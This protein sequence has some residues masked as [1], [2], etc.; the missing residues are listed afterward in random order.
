MNKNISQLEE[1]IKYTFKD[2]SLL[3][4]ALTHSSYANEHKYE[5]PYNERLEFL[6]DA[7]VSLTT[8]RFL[9]EKFPDMPEGDLSKLRS[10]L[11]CTAA[12]SDYA[13]QI[14]LG[15]YLYLGKGEE[16]NGGRTRPSNLE[17]AF[18]A[19]TAAIYLDS[20]LEAASKFVLRFL[21]VSINTHHINFKDY[22]TTLQ[23]VVQ[24]NH[25]ETLNYVIT[26]ESGP[27]HDKR[28]EAEVH[29]NSNVIGRG[30]GTSKK[31]AEQEAAKEA[32]QLMGI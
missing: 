1:T 24:Q 19:L 13:N 20:G 8:A 3:K 2:K 25:Q 11:V 29:L 17:D 7:V 4:A 5:C 31:Q 30:T 27:A 16:G 18:E 12:L 14:S 28:F 21:S 10:S 23:E 15:D 26:S 32:L 9:F 6:G 22:K